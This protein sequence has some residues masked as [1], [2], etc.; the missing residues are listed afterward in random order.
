MAT[1]DAQ[2]SSAPFSMPVVG[3]VAYDPAGGYKAPSDAVFDTE[4]HLCYEPPSKKYTFDDLGLKKGI[5]DIAITEAFPCLTPAAVRELRKDCLSTKVL[6][7]FTHKSKLAAFQAR[8][9]HPK[10]APFVAQIFNS[11]EFIAA[12]SN[13]AGIELVPI[14][15]LEL[16]H[17]NYQLGKDGA[18]GIRS[19]TADPSDPEPPATGPIIDDGTSVVNWHYDAY[20]F[21]AVTMLSDVTNMV[22][23]ETAIEKGDGTIARIRGPTLGCTTVMQG[24]YVKHIACKAYNAKERI[25]MVTSFRAKDVLLPDE[26]ILTTIRPTTKANRINAQWS[27]YRLRV[28]GECFIT[29]FAL[30]EACPT[31]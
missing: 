18:Q 9:F 5:T 29:I 20:P 10:V 24:R 12:C 11:P 8:E 31:G 2:L 15:P 6:N 21:V 7:D 16:G 1:I 14:M 22:G 26:S 30:V 27:T 23:G 13:A 4:V 19:L 25:T 3:G 17:T 28:V